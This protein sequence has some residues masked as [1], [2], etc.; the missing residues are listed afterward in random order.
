MFI[1]TETFAERGWAVPAFRA[2]TFSAR[3]TRYVVVIPVLNEGQ[4]IRSQLRRMHDLGISAEADLAIVDGG[5]SDGSLEPGFL[6]S[7]G[8]RALLIKTGAGRLS[9][10]LR[11]GYAWS[12]CE[13]YDGIVTIDG[14]DKDGVETIPSFLRALD[15]GYGYAQA[16]RFIPGGHS[17]NTPPLRLLAIRLFH[18]P[19]LS[20]AAGTWLTDTTQGYRAY[21]AAF[22]ADPRTQPFRDIFMGYELLA[23]LTVRASQLEYRVIEL[24]TSRV[25]PSG[26]PVPTKINSFAAQ[27]DLVHILLRTVLR[28]YH[29]DRDGAS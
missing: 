4:R 13:G 16:S 2:D 5:S 17:A 3:T 11:C 28:H 25:Y 8:V 20:L 23:Y 18:A 9:A 22:L 10:Q 1:T 14:N 15:D 12:L 27:L 26:G 19:M 24:P 21:S 29:P 6:R 7:V